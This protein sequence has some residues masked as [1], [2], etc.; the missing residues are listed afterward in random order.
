MNAICV[1]T[2]EIS[3][4]FLRIFPTSGNSK[5]DSAPANQSSMSMSYNGFEVEQVFLQAGKLCLSV[6]YSTG[7]MIAHTSLVI[8]PLLAQILN[9]LLLNPQLLSFMTLISIN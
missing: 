4:E 6:N 7:K 3:V 5:T 8:T 9:R 1:Q 2:L